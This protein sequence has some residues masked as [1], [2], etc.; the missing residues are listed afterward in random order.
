MSTTAPR[1]VCVRVC[2]SVGA[3]MFVCMCVSL[4]VFQCVCWCMNVYVCVCV[5]VCYCMN[6]CTLMCTGTNI[7]QLSALLVP[8]LSCN[9]RLHFGSIGALEI[10]Y[11]VAIVAS[12]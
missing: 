9:E 6:G 10:S 3:C 8:S 11:Y 12:H 1:L 7:M 4:C 2:E 5:C